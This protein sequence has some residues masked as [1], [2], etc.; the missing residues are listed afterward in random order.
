MEKYLKGMFQGNDVD[1]LYQQ[2]DAFIRKYYENRLKIGVVI[3]GGLGLS[4]LVFASL[5]EHLGRF[6]APVRTFF[7]LLL[8]MWFIYL[9]IRY[10]LIPIRA[11][12]LRKKIM[13]YEKASR[14]LGRHF[15]QIN[16]KFLNAIQLHR[17]S[18][19]VQD[20]MWI[21]ASI[22]QKIHEIK[23]I[24]FFQA[25]D[26]NRVFRYA[27]WAAFPILLTFIILIWNPEIITGSGERL[28]YFQKHYAPPAPFTFRL[29]N[30]SLKGKEGEDF[31]IQVTTEGRVAPEEMYIYIGKE[32]YRMLR[33]KN[34]LFIHKISQLSNSTS[35]YFQS[36]DYSSAHFEISVI[37]LPRI[38]NF[39]VGLIY[40]AYL[41]KP[42]EV[43]QNVGDII[44]PEGTKIN[45]K[46]ATRN[47]NQL[48]L[49][50]QNGKILKGILKDGFFNISHVGL[51]SDIYRL[52]P[53]NQHGGPQDSIA[54]QMTVIPDA[55]P[56]MQVESQTDSLNPKI[57]FFSGTLSDDYG[58]SKL[59]FVYTLLHGDGK[60]EAEN[61][62]NVRI[63]SGDIRQPFYQYYDAGDLPLMPGDQ[64][65]Y[66]FEVWDNDG[67]HGPKS[68]KSS[69]FSYKAPTL[70]EVKKEK[71]QSS[72]SLKSSME[73][74]LKNAVQL[75]Q[76]M[77][78]ME[79]KMTEKK[80]MGWEEKKQL[81][82]LI[83]KQ[84]SLRQ[85]IETI[86]QEFKRNQEK[87]KELNQDQLE[88]LEKQEQLQKLMDQLLNEE[89][90][91]MM[92]EM[93]ELLKKQDKDQI[94]DQLKDMQVQDKEVQK[95]L[96][97]MLELFK[98]LELAEKQED[99][100]KKLE[101]LE[102]KQE[103]LAEESQDKN[104][105]PQDLQKKQQELN[106]EFESLKKELDKLS[107][108]NQ[109]LEEPLP[110]EN[111]KKE[112]DE[113]SQ[114]QEQSNQ[115][116]GQGKKKQASEKQK[117]AAS[118]MKEMRKKMEKNMEKQEME[119]QEEDYQSL[120]QI[121]E[122]LVDLSFGQEK[123]MS[124]LKEVKGYSPQYVKIGQRQK[125][126][127]DDA[128]IIEDSLLALSKRVA[129]IQSIINREIGQVNGFMDK[130]ISDL[131]A[132]YTPQAL[133]NQ[134]QVM[135]H[136]NNLAVLLSDVMQQMQQ[137]MNDKKEGQGSGGKGQKKKKGKGGNKG[138]DLQS[139][140][141]MQE[142]L[143]KQLQKMREG[144]QPGPNGQPGNK[145]FAQAAAKQAAIR[146]KMRQ[147]AQQY[148]KEGST[149]MKNQLEQLQ[150]MMEQQEKD[151]YN[152]KLT[153]ETLRRQQEIT[154]RLLE[155]EKAELERETDQIRQATQ[156]K[157][158]PP[159]AVKR[160]EEYK[161]QKS[162]DNESLRTVPP[163]LTPY[164][165]EK[166]K[167]YYQ[168]TRP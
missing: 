42:N 12:W 76:E 41:N 67:V 7:A 150:R 104:S 102:Q 110:L 125:K 46:L 40:P 65:E 57:R 153:S 3:F 36:G 82:E 140:R 161:K 144:Q 30:K 137:N 34:G 64:V 20:K 91:E 146:Q 116:L 21:E 114:D 63:K 99:I 151:L 59:Q 81:E 131:S 160:F 84:E 87:S 92:K 75:Q 118:R 122:N 121:M 10:L 5:L 49:F 2:L 166:V 54:Y 18:L 69:S 47:T 8:M 25:I 148:G 152:K 86:Q 133:V 51:Q 98:K 29:L 17:N 159:Q 164:Y 156:G 89:L 37:P 132:R 43:L 45:W 117:K 70:E 23:P 139:M 61:R 165:R 4:T 147:L 157:D 71:Q 149:Q 26:T 100:L 97:R 109:K 168:L 24:P 115:D 143:S 135:T 38:N 119:Q 130:S 126:L 134:Q 101:E 163:S 112:E 155:S 44:V 85:E 83:K 128:R 73:K 56:T 124:D 107:Q 22:A 58:I 78:K 162:G 93:Q 127:K 129:A 167:S 60:K 55:Y 120:R 50:F 123:L 35:I 113:I 11:L 111:T 48:Q 108:E 103:K 1:W 66:Y 90:R 105:N 138:Q 9:G 62:I 6:G 33:A 39:E 27:K 136:V 106:K 88:S 15:P 16:D 31:E 74:A 145:E 95:E 158:L 142:E 13:S 52:V 80:S 68:V 19:T 94:K 72:Q 96:D 28:I 32:S 154:S 14:I 79:E 77:R 53:G 141:K